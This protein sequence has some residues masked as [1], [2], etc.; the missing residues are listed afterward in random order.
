MR[1]EENFYGADRY[2][3]CTT[4]LREFDVDTRRGYWCGY[5]RQD[6]WIGDGPGQ[7]LPTGAPRNDDPQ[8]KFPSVC[9]GYSTSL[10]EV[11]EASRALDWRRDGM[12]SEFFAGEPVPETAKT[13]I[14]LLSYE[15]RNVERHAY[16]AARIKGKKGTDG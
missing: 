12:L 13:F 7:Q 4:C 5:I 11:I 2:W 16:R 14:D 8:E 3:N 15:I 6:K 9:P 10:P 1:D